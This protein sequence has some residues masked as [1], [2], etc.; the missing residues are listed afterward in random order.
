MSNLIPDEKI[1][2]KIFLIR[3]KK[4][5]LDKDLAELYG[6]PIKRLNEQV[7]RNLGR[8]PDD[9]MFQLR[10]EEAISLRSQIATLKRGHHRKYL[11]YAF[12]EQGVAMLSSVLNSKRAI[13]VNILI[14]RTFTKLRE[15]LGA[16]KE[17]KDKLSELEAKVTKH[18]KEIQ[19]I[20]DAI[21]KLIE[22]QVTKFKGKV[23]FALD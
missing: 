22:P 12:T 23:G 11:P 14:M 15:M 19:S 10:E 8:F 1:E 16:N 4:V 5:M 17:L 3:G 6:V 21:H 18:D 9:F 20:F 7:K 2:K 13:N